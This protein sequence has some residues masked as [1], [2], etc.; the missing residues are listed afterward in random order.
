MF[1]PHLSWQDSIW[2]SDVDDTLIDTAGTSTSASDGIKIIFETHFG[3]DKASE[4]QKNFN[5]LFALMMAGYR[6]QNDDWARVRGGRKAFDSLLEYVESCQQ[7][8]VR[9]HGHFKKW[10]REI[11]IK[12]ASEQAN[13]VVTPELVHEAADAYWLTLTKR[14]VIFPDAIKLSDTIAARHRPLFLVTSSDARLKMQPDGQFVYDPAYSE[15]LKRQRMELL[16]ERGLRF[17][18]VSI[19]DPEDKPHPDFFAKAIRLA[20]AD[21]GITFEP[22]H[23]IM[24]GDS[25]GGDLQT[26]KDKLGFGLVVLREK[27]RKEVRHDDD[28]QV[29]LGDLNEVFR[30]FS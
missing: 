12:R 20:E 10:S 14:T 21:L 29:T 24:L 11:F 18:A 27:G 13:L 7:Q 5:D 28:H 23:A 9:T 1:Q 16:R 26:P 15:A 17:N 30:L 6:V 19:G 4:V 3:A 25:F 2:F 22:S 8:V